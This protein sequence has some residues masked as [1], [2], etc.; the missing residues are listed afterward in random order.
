MTQENVNTMLDSSKV[1]GNI[2]ALGSSEFLVR[3]IAFLSMAYVARTLGPEGFGIIGFSIAI[4]GFFSLALSS[5]TDEVCSREVARRPS[6]A[7]IIGA[8][9]IAI[10][11][12]LAI[13]FFGAVIL[14]ASFLIKPHTVKLVV[15]LFGLSF[16]S[17]ALNPS[18]VYKGLE[19]NVRVG[20]A[21]VLGQVLYVG[22]V[23][24]VVKK[25]A[26]VVYIPVSL[27]FGEITAALF[28]GV[29]LFRF[30]PITVRLSEGVKVLFS[31][32]ALFITKFLRTL[33]YSFDVLLLGFLLGER[34]VGLYS[35]PYR[36]CF[37][38]I[39]IISSIYVSY[40]PA[41]TRAYARDRK[42]FAV[43]VNGFLELSSALGLPL[44]IGGMITASH[45]LNAVFGPDYLEGT[46]AFQLLLLSTGLIFVY[47][48][49]HGILLA[50]NNLKA[51]MWIIGMGV[52]LNVVLN[53][54][55]IP[56]YG[57]A[58]AATATVAAEGLILFLGLIV[59][60]RIGVRLDFWVTVR[61]F[62]AAAVMAV[63]LTALGSGHNIALYI[64]AGFVTYLVVLVT[65]KGIPRDAKPG[66]THFFQAANRLCNK[67][68]KV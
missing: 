54:F 62:L 46:L 34:Q 16:F 26:D 13:A 1:V 37:F 55:L 45:L 33:I 68:P 65:L 24:L 9:V 48:V 23:L 56:I 25:P 15:I 52:V 61:P 44:V 28:L 41:L 53:I 66:L 17:L 49:I 58:G 31:T 38:L 60:N 35:A 43:V 32:W 8:S 47:S 67:T 57:L 22:A 50:S 3:M 63:A 11:L 39:A 18:W 12:M 20:F 5:G 6:D 10:R 51:E 2:V 40:L 4:C 64:G 29:A 21:L 14:I 19:R 30:R 27:F 36:I 42:Q 59:V 7:R